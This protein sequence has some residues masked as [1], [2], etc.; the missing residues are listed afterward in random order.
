DGGEEA[1]R[2]Y[3]VSE[4]NYTIELL[5]PRAGNKHAVFFTHDR[6]RI[7][8]HYERKL[9]DVNGVKRADPRVS[10]TMTLEVD[11]F[12][13][14]LRELAINY[15]RRDLPGVDLPEQKETHLILT[16]NRF[17]N[18]PNETD[19]YRLGLVVES[20]TYEVVKPPEPQIVDPRAV[21]FGFGQ[22]ATLAANL[23]PIDD[24]EP[25]N[26][27]LWP[28]EKWDWRANLNNAPADTRLRLI[29]RLR[30]LYRK[31]DLTGLLPLGEIESLALPGE[32]YK[33][34]LTPGL[35]SSVFKREQGGQPPEDLLP[36]PAPLLEG[37]GA[38]EGG[39]VW[40]D[41]AWW[42]PSGRAFFDPAANVADPSLTAAQELIAAR[43]HFFL[44]RKFADPFGHS[45]MVAYDAHRLLIVSTQDA[46]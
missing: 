46:L 38:D 31:D 17:A 25:E 45:A 28:Y 6:E 11:P 13:N 26:A 36:N 1:D 35:L 7:D 24:A 34:A 40:I 12:G 37:K 14:T 10:H 29:E 18:R 27:K 39:Y 43:Q 21:P 15:R 32:L 20:Q 33:L 8:F 22:M 5:Q 42:I 4:R 9:V 23:F 16:A 2:P 19:W 30:T 3:A 44:T 41:G